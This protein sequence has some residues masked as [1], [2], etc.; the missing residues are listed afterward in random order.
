MSCIMTDPNDNPTA[1]VT[2]SWHVTIEPILD[3]SCNERDTDS[4]RRLLASLIARQIASDLQA[5]PGRIFEELPGEDSSDCVSATATAVGVGEAAKRSGLP[6][7]SPSQPL[8][9]CPKG[10]E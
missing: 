8:H 6:T 9:N 10:G 2:S 5:L 7:R 1:S 3:R 4:A